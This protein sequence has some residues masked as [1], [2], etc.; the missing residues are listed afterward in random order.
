MWKSN[1]TTHGIPRTY[2]EPLNEPLGNA[3]ASPVFTRIGFGGALARLTAH[4]SYRYLLLGLRA[5]RALSPLERW[6]TQFASVTDAQ[7][8]N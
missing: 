7:S 5:N 6:E 3:H 8:C 1:V 2:R 4:L